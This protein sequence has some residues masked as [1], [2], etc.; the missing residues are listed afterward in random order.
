VSE[1]LTHTKDEVAVV[2]MEAGIE[3][4]GRGVETS[5][6]SVLIVAEPSF[7]SLELAEKI[8]ALAAEVGVKRVWTVLN[9]VGSKEMA[10]ILRREL[11]DRGISII[12][13]IGYEP[14]IL[15]AGLEGRPVRRDKLET[16]IGS[17]LDQV[18]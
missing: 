13:S 8:S 2:D 4:F 7:D 5:I 18:L 16:D 3:H 6:D 9:K 10:L 17:M 14:E 15:Q 12:G 11:E 1:L